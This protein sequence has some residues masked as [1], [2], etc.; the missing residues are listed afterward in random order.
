MMSFWYIACQLLQPEG[1]FPVEA[2][3]ALNVRF[4]KDGFS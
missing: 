2:R 3:Q 1:R 4:L